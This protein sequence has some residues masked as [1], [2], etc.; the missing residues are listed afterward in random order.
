MSTSKSIRRAVRYALLTSASIV[1][2]SA[3]S[4]QAAEDSGNIS[5]VVVTGSR[6]ASPNL[7][8][9][10][11][12]K[13]ITE[14][15][16]AI[17]GKVRVEDFL[18]Q[19]PQAFAAQGSNISNGSDGTATVDLRGL[20]ARRTLVLVNGRRLM[21]GD[22]DGGNEADLNQIPG[23]LIKRVDV[24]TGGAS[25][26]YGADAVAG[27]VNFIMDTEF[28]GL[29]IDA[30]YGGFQHKNDNSTGRFAKQSGFA[31]PDEDFTG[32]YSKEL[33]FALGIGAPG[34]RGHATFYASYR[35]TDPVLQRDFDYSACT[36][37]NV[38]A[39]SF[40]CGGSQTTAPAAFF[41]PSGTPTCTDDL[42]C[43]VGA[44]N[45][46]RPFNTDTDLFNFG[47]F[48]Y[49]QRPDER[50]T[51]GVFANFDVSDNAEAYAE[52]MFMDD[53]SVLQL[54]PSGAFFNGQMVNCDSPLLSPSMVD[55]FC[56]SQMLGPTDLA[57]VFIGRRNIEGG[58]R[59]DDIS[60]ESYRIVTGLRGDI[61]ENWSYD[62]Y[63]QHGITKR[64]STFKND[65]SIART[66]RA[67]QVR[68]DASGV[69]QCVSFLDGSD[70]NC[71]PYNIFQ[72]GGVT[73]AA[74]AYLQTPGI[75]RAQARQEIAHIDV[76]GNLSE[77]VQLPG[78]ASGLQINVGAEYR[79][80]KTEF[81]PDTQ[82]LI[83]DLSGQ[84]GAT[85]AV[86]GRF[87]VKEAFIEARL[88]LL[89]D[90]PA[91]K[92]VSFETAYRY[93]DYS[94]DFTTDTYK[95]GLDWEPID[96]VRLRGSFQ[97]AV[98][99]PNIGELFAPQTV[100]LD[101]ST[102]PCAGAVTAAT[103]ALPL[104]QQVLGSG[105]TFA[106]CARSGV[107]PARFGRIAA[108]PAAQYNGLLGGSIDAQPETADTISFGVV[109]KADFANLT[110]AL[111]YFD[112]EIEDTLTAT[113]GGN[114][115]TFLNECLNTGDPA[116]CSRI[117]RSAAL[118]SLFLTDDGFIVDTVDN[119][120][121]LRTT[122]VD[123]QVNYGLNVGA[124]R[125][126][127]AL[128][129][130]Y[131]DELSSEPIA[132]GNSFD[133][134]G[135][136]GN[137]CGVPAPE[138]RSSLRTTW[139]TPWAGLDVNLTWRFFD[140]VK[141]ERTSSDTQLAGLFASTDAELSSRSY[142]DLTLVKTFADQYTLRLGAS[143]LLDK[144]PPIVGSGN[145]RGNCPSGFCNGNT[146]P[147]VYDSLGRQWF[148][149]VTV[150]F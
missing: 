98:R 115:D 97:R 9:I 77:F 103:A 87:D 18:N 44:G 20:G 123:V 91:A 37:N 12:I 62:G 74:L 104:A 132:N 6:I 1:A 50:Y 145:A 92:S 108:N 144:D 106:E 45:V 27:V 150:D 146:Y 124:S 107:T 128:T 142:F 143:N 21:P 47:P 2:V 127:F 38:S 117:N 130:T 13:A 25:S 7:E 30:N 42:G 89:Q 118:G 121:V 40:G 51:A 23:A 19:L 66:G 100:N 22:P 75:I 101:G 26:V 55:Q 3:T 114:A 58:G 60:H 85:A 69:P 76:S 56:T 133:C 67:L 83:G 70:P 68:N 93:S 95:F 29:R 131:L 148:G 88:P 138:W 141:S 28:E 112:I 111:D 149:S 125:L 94:V 110:V 53:R 84:G 11:P 99:A 36:L 43:I 31:T 65:F 54:A 35:E 86:T 73:P 102:D 61:S 140:S 17:S 96:S 136:Y 113:V 116:F 64:N 71:V 24:L 90:R 10:S 34:D 49:S 41:L 134:K 82:F 32:G 119:I 126:A 109:Y 137:Q 139:G 39:T 135:L 105:R 81:Q 8:S 63:L 14:E 120:G 147:Q 46:L 52:L 33:T 5:E 15:D 78:T 57:T 72:V 4:A 129:G 59:Q 48:N 122:G 79:D 16:I 80:E